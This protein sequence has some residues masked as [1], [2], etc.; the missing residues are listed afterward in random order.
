MHLKRNHHPVA[1][2]RETVLQF[3]DGVFLRGFADWIIHHM[4]QKGLFQGG[5]VAVNPRRTGNAEKLNDQDGLYTVSIQ[6]M[7][8]GTLIKSDEIVSCIKRGIHPYLNY[9]S[10]MKLAESNDLR[11][12]IS[13]TTEAGIRYREG[14][15]LNDQ[16]QESFPGKLAAFLY[17]RY[18]YFEGNPEKGLIFLPCELVANNGGLLRE[19]ILRYAG[20]WRLESAFTDWVKQANTFCNTLVDR[21]VPGYSKEDSLRIQQEYGYEDKLAIVAEPYYKWIIDAPSFVQEEF[22]AAAAGLQVQF[23]SDLGPY[24]LL[25][26]R[27]LNGLHT[28]IMPIAYLAGK[29][30]VREATEDPLI[31]LLLK[32]LCYE[33]IIPVLGVGEEEAIAFAEA[34]FER[35]RN[36]FIRHDL[37]SISLNSISKFR[38]RNVPTLKAYIESYGRVPR[39]LSFSLSALLVFYRGVRAGQ[40][41]PLND[42]GDVLEFF[43]SIWSTEE[44]SSIQSTVSKILAKESL[45][46][47]DLTE[48]DELVG[49]VVKQVEMML[50]YGMGES[51]KRLFQVKTT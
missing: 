29:E 24:A 34:I 31:G 11:F 40:L 12:V 9:P 28:A 38:T 6:G 3:G 46:G 43:R 47:E 30:T 36:P 7:H 23:V 5:V 22:P 33:E 4:N 45:W 42:Q 20:E 35:F 1:P 10:Y 15:R 49:Q 39:Y 48:Y 44:E 16:P 27:I 13:N 2:Q 51:L 17:R 19:I 41:I 50:T 26:V 18:Q 25:K 37:S 21:I 8:D 14:E 32:S